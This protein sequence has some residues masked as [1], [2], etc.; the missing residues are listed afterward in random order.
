[1]AFAALLFT[2]S[3]SGCG[4]SS[5][6][7]GKVEPCGGSLV[8]SWNVTG[9]C[10]NSAALM[11]SLG[12]DFSTFCPTATVSG[13]SATASGSL[14]FNADMTYSANLTQGSTVAITIPATCLSGA[15]CAV[16]TAAIQAQNDP[17]LQ[18]ISCTGT[19][20]C[21]CT[22]VMAPMTTNESGTYTT[23]GTVATLTSS[24]GT[25]T[26]GDYCV[27]ANELHLVTVDTT[28]NMGPMGQATIDEDIVAAK[29]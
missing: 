17:A 23:S 18:S 11:S 27:Q 13:A 6:S 7:C 12:S 29:K 2:A 21:T 15:S 4:G 24:T 9:A 25:T 22:G 5:G 28:T 14:T 3:F 10:V 16:L 1:M 26:V 20:S 8:G 19:G